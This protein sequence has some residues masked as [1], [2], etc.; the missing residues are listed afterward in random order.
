[1][2]KAAGSF[3]LVLLFAFAAG[4]QRL[5]DLATPE[6]YQITVAP[7]LER[8]TF[9]GEETIEIRVL[10]PTSSKSAIAARAHCQFGSSS[11]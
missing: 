9:A 6:H 4:A 2:R 11:E 7:D 8:E 5:P 1:M 10:K 3:A